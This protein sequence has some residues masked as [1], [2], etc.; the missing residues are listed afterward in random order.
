MYDLMI[1]VQAY[2]YCVN[3]NILQAKKQIA[4]EEDKKMAA[5]KRAA[6]NIK[7]LQE[8]KA[9]LQADIAQLSSTLDKEIAELKGACNT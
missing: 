9:K 3:Y 8:K 4:S 1:T 7:I 2:N 6:E 5:R